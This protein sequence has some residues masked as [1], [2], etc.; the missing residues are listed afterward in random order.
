MVAYGA[1]D[2]SDLSEEEEEEEVT[3]KP[4]PGSSAVKP[5]PFVEANGNI[6]DE[7]DEFLGGGG[8]EDLIPEKEEPDV[9]SLIAK[10]LPQALKAKKK[11]EVV[12][13]TGPIPEKKDYGDKVEEPPAKK[14]KRSGPVKITI[15]SLSTFKEEEEEAL[16]SVRVE[17]SKAGSGLFALL[18]QPKNKPSRPKAV[19]PIRPTPDAAAAVRKP[20]ASNIG[21]NNLKPSGVRTVGMNF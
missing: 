8:D 13:E 16:P 12:E 17:P 20:L 1:S 18:P 5:T 21:A 11:V 7:E 9:F 3:K 15:P 10:K 14:A 4:V 19:V 6:S 2:D